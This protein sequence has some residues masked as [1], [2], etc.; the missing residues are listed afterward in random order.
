MTRKEKR[1]IVSENN[2]FGEFL[3]I[4]KHFFKKIFVQLKNVKDIRQTGKVIYS[5]DILL[6]TIIMKNCCS[7]ITM[8]EMKN[9]FNTNNSVEN[10][11]K[12]MGYEELEELPHYDTINN[13][14]KKLKNDQLEKIRKYMIKELLNK[15]S[16][17]HYRYND[18]YWTIAVDATGMFSFNKKH[19]KHCLKRTYR[20]KI[21]GEI[22]REEYYHNVLE[23]KLVIGDMVFSIET[24]F[25][26]NEHED[27]EKQDCE[28]KAFYRLAKKLKKEYP[29][30]PICILGDSLYACDRVFEICKENGWKYILRFKE[31]SIPSIAKEFNAILKIE[32]KELKIKEKDEKE[33]IAKLYKYVNE[34]DYCDKKINMVEYREQRE[35]I[36]DEDKKKSE[37][38]FV[39][40]T[41]IEISERKVEKIVTTGRS[42]WKIEN[43]A[44]NNQKNISY[45]IEHACCLDYNAIK[46]H[47]LLIQIADILKQLFEKGAE[48]LR[49]LKLG[50][51]EISSILK[52]HF[53]QVP[54]KIEDISERRIQIRDL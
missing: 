27:V 19:C 17:E 9:E 5:P 26:E 7:I 54:L 46:N 11:A 30:L 21:T 25:I 42:R 38:T 2:F 8:N 13:F 24:E 51:K 40:I 20:N 3:I 23:A 52:D 36:N 1:K 4:K 18:K 49:V 34:I 31:G 35:R 53:R 22:E 44:F 12:A 48:I 50:K 39:F 6:F 10:M 16:L 43:E 14:L 37:S 47:Y 28:R 45:D 41:N 15:R 32:P 33:N 29:R